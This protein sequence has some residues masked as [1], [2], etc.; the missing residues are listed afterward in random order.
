M[1][2]LWIIA[3]ISTLFLINEWIVE[4][5]EIKSNPYC[6]NMDEELKNASRRSLRKISLI[7]ISSI[8]WAIIIVC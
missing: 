2:L 3:L 7:V 6:E 1:I 4:Y 5:L 8:M